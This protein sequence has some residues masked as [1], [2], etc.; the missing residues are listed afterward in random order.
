MK[1]KSRGMLGKW[2]SFKAIITGKSFPQCDLLIYC[3][4][5]NASKLQVRRQNVTH[6]QDIS[7]KVP[8]GDFHSIV[9]WAKAWQEDFCRAIKTLHPILKK[10]TMNTLPSIFLNMLF[11]FFANIVCK[12]LKIVLFLDSCLVWSMC[13]PNDQLYEI[14][15]KKERPCICFW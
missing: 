5:Y 15:Q 14:W 7:N 11:L 6:T 4:Y 13:A 2:F 1:S 8:M 10:I 12:F 3:A 9:S